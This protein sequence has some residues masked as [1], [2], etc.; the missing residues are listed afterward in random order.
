LGIRRCTKIFWNFQKA[1]RKQAKL[2]TEQILQLLDIPKQGDILDV[3]CGQGF[4]VLEFG[5][6]G[7]NITGI[8][9]AEFPVTQSKK[10]LS[11]VKKLHNTS[12]A[13]LTN[14][15]ERTI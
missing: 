8:E 9:I 1:P 12:N 14:Y 6:K 10:K 5:E 15:L 4:H 11:H 13:R 7:Y 2:E 3:G